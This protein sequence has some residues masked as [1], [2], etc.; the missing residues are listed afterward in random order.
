MAWQGA[1]RAATA[2]SPIVFGV[3]AANQAQVLAAQGRWARHIPGILDHKPWDRILLGSQP[4]WMR[5]TGHTLRMSIRAER[6]NRTPEASAA[7]AVG[8]G[9]QFAARRTAVNVMR[10][11]GVTNAKY[12][13]TCAVD[14]AR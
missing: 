3:A 4:V 13:A 5:D 1:S 9:P 6:A 14:P 7:A 11:R 8:N 10:A 2:T 12:I